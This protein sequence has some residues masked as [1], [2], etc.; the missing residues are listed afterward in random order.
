MLTPI[1]RRL[2]LLGLFLAAALALQAQTGNGS[3]VG[4][5]KDASGA[6]VPTAQVTLTHTATSETFSATT[7]GAG[8]YVFPSLVA[9]SYEI[10]ISAKGM[11]DWKAQLTLLAM[12]RADVDATLS[13]GSAST[14][15]EVK[16]DAAP[17][18][19]TTS[20]TLS[21]VL[22]RERVEQ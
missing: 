2:N 9:G 11:R 13:V 7:N 6:V 18:V 4:T 10:L 1:T 8:L 22:E 5:V 21:N 12:Q 19:N 20:G 16:G 14:V 15:V 3:I 17:L